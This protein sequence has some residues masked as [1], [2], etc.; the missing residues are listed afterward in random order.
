MVRLAVSW[1][2]ATTNSLT[3]RLVSGFFGFMAFLLCY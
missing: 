2:A 1:T 3:V